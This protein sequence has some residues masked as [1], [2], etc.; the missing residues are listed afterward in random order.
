MARYIPIGDPANDAETEG[1]RLLRDTL[2]DH[3]VVLGNF[4]LCLPR[5][6]NSLE[7]D[8]VVIGEY[9]IYAVEM[10]GWRG[11]IEGNARRWGLA[12]GVVQNPFINLERK[13]KALREFIGRAVPNL[14]PSI[15]CAAVVFFPRNDVEF[16]IED[17]WQKQRLRPFELWNYFVDQEQIE[18]QGPGPL[19]D[20]QL[21]DR[22]VDA[23][24]P[25]ARPFERLVSVAGYEIEGELDREGKPYREF[26]GSHRLLQNRRRARIKAYTTDPLAP[27]HNRNGD[28]NRILRDMEA[29]ESLDDNPYVARSY[30]TVQDREDELIFYL[31]SEWV[32][33]RTLG[34]YIAEENETDWPSD[35]KKIAER[36]S[37]A[38][39]LIQ[40]VSFMHARKIIH[41]NLH[42]GV[43]YLTRSMASVPL[44]IADFD[45]ARV[46][47]LKTIA[48]E[49]QSIGTD[50]YR[51][52]ELWV[53]DV[54]D[55]RVDIFSLGA[56]VFELLV[57]QPLFEN[58]SDILQQEEIWRERRRLLPDDRVRAV[59]DAMIDADV[60]RRVAHLDDALALFREVTP[61]T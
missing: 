50:G 24:R 18:A 54:H 5:R 47:N 34:D 28:Y 8:A 32:G 45:Y 31:I 20:P 59:L 42:P 43:I 49:L 48:H 30:E 55:H 7:Y 58:M 10:K 44:K 35:P 27:A 39:H 11:T 19:L 26:V 46:G 52:P 60:Q 57:G 38:H 36:W 29:L 51:A 23:I 37:Y 22:V 21:R 56:I 1:F 9:G 12:W 14:P 41:R 15:F 40:A 53:D 25:C 61:G 6:R 33:P 16:D 3:F 2:P 4:D 17:G 13:A